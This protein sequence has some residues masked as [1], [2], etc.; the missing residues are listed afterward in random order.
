[1]STNRNPTTRIPNSSCC[2]TSHGDIS[3]TKRGIIGPPLANAKSSPGGAPRLLV[4]YI[5]IYCWLLKLTANIFRRFL[6]MWTFK[7]L[8]FASVRLFP[9]VGPF[10]LLQIAW[11]ICS[12]VTLI[13]LMWS[14]SSVFY[15]VFSQIGDLFGWI[16][17]LLKHPNKCNQCDFASS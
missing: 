12:K 6:I 7:I 4:I 8:H 14:L 11:M 2:C 5:Y 17:A 16:V 1:M 15:Y 3:G 9:R 13:A 10:V